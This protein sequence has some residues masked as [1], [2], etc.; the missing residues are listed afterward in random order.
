MDNPDLWEKCAD[1]D[2][3]IP[4][5]WSQ[6]G[7]NIGGH[8]VGTLRRR[9][10]CAGCFAEPRVPPMPALSEPGGKRHSDTVQ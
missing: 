6:G 7:M 9:R 3:D 10:I 5:K 8:M 4:P 2:A 1:C